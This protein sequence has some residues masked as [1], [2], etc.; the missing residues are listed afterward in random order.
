MNT[1]ED[2]CETCGKTTLWR[3]LDCDECKNANIECKVSV[4]TI[5]GEGYLGDD[6][7]DD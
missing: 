1:Y 4:C 2:H 7:E 3:W 6:I 5:C